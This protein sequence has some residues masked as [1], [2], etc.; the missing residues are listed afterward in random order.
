[1]GRRGPPPV[2]TALL[3]ARGSPRGLANPDEPQPESG[4]PQCPEMLSEAAR[5]VWAQVVSLIAAGVLTKDGAQTLARY[6][7]G[8]VRWWK[9]AEWMEQNEDTYE[10]KDAQLNTRYVRHPNV[11]TYE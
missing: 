9:L 8:V 3:Q 10:I 11:I 1:M 7:H 2:P 5:A 4:A 6:C